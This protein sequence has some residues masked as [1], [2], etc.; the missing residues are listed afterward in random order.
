MNFIKLFPS[1][2]FNREE[3]KFVYSLNSVFFHRSGC[4]TDQLVLGLKLK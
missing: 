2:T 1:I 4:S 3:G